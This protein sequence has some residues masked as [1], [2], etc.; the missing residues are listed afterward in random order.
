VISRWPTGSREAPADPSSTVDTPHFVFVLVDV[1]TDCKDDAAASLFELGASGIEERDEQTLV[2]GPGPEQA[3]LVASF[4]DMDAASQ[5][6]AALSPAWSP[7]VEQLVGDAWLDA[8]KKHFAPFR[9]T[10]RITVRPPWQRHEPRD[11]GE[12]VL[13]LEPGRAFGTGLHATTALVARALDALAP[14]LAGARVLDVGTGSGILALV[15][16]AL[17]ASTVHAIDVD[18]DAIAVAQ[19]NFR[20]N[21]VAARNDRIQAST[22]PLALLRDTYDIVA[23]NIEARTLIDLAGDLARVTTASTAL[24]PLTAGWLILSGILLPQAADVRAAFP[25]FSLEQ[26]PEN[27]EWTALVMRRQR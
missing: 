1:A 23:A 26:S 13:E 18:P 20:R 7:R 19:E 11:E 17:G 27:G 2:R 4:A 10:E 22:T 8:W 6:V 21:L 24:S 3:T 5:A 12:I 15:A 9:L 14:R 16:A 25:D